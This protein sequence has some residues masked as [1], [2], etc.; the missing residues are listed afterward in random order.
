MPFHRPSGTRGIFHPYPV[1]GQSPRR[2][3]FPDASG[4]NHL[5]EYARAVR[6]PHNLGKS[7]RQLVD[8]SSYPAADYDRDHVPFPFQHAD[9]GDHA[10]DE[11]KPIE[12]AAHGEKRV[13]TEPDRQVQDHSD[14]GGGDGGER[15]G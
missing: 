4:V 9:E 13:Q 14:N 8:Q 11:S 7:R 10:R 6:L 3:N 2:P 1:V 5:A 12:R 15:G